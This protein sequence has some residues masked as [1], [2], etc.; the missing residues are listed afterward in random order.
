[1]KAIRLVLH[2]MGM[3]LQ[4]LV[5]AVIQGGKVM[6]A[7][8]G[9][10]YNAGAPVNG[11]DEVQTLTVT[12]TPTGGT[13]KLTYEGFE[14]PSTIAYNANAAAVQAALEAIPAIGSGGVVCG[15]GALPGVA[16]TITGAGNLG[17]KALSLITVT[18]KAFTGGSSP[19]AAVVETTPGVDATARGAEPGATL[20]DTTNKKEYINT[21]TAL[22]PTWT[23]KGTQT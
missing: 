12:G 21:G 7:T 23:V 18:S 13:F 8:F 16:V 10:Y 20:V 6:E 2:L 14:T 19:D 1:M 11:T 4:L 9:P 5:A 15:G 22:A 3:L 17:K